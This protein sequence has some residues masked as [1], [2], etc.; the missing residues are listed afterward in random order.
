MSVDLKKGATVELVKT[1]SDDLRTKADGTKANSAGEAVR[2]QISD[3]KSHLNN[4][5][6]IKPNNTTFFD[7][8]N[9][10]DSDIAV[11]GSGLAINAS[12]QLF[13]ASANAKYLIIP[14]K[15]STTYILYVPEGNR[16]YVGENETDEFLSGNTITMLVTANADYPCTF[17]TGANAHY[18]Y[19]YI[20]SGDYDYAN[21]KEQI[22]LCVGTLNYGDPVLDNK[23]IGKLPAEKL[24]IFMGANLFDPVTAVYRTDRNINT[25]GTLFSSSLAK[26]ITFPVEPDTTYSLYVPD[27]NRSLVAEDNVDG[28]F[29]IG[30]THTMLVTNA[31][32]PYPIKFTTGASAKYVFVTI[33]VGDYDYNN[34]KAGIKLVK[35]KYWDR[36]E[37]YIPLNNM[38]DSLNNLYGANVLIFGDSITDCCN[39]TTNSDNE[40]TAYSWKNP[41]NSYIDGNGNAIAY[42]MWAK[43]LKENQPLGEIRNYALS[44]ASIISAEREAGSERLNLQYQ[45]D[46][47]LNDVDN[48]NGVFAVDHYVPDIVIFAIGTNDVTP[49]DTYE[50]AMSVVTYQTDGVSVDVSATMAQLDPTKFCESAR[51]AFLKIKQAFP[52]AQ[53]YFVLPLQ[54]ARYQ[55]NTTNMHAELKKIAERYGCI[56]IDGTFMSGV[57]AEFETVSHLGALL[58]DGLHPNDKGQNVMARMILSALKANYQP[59]GNGFNIIT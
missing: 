40:T 24:D 9:Y 32:L 31:T 29:A 22:R 25:S 58:K 6:P 10:F 43:I 44:G 30:S 56:I 8:V 52:L 17:T 36:P 2:E 54:R 16:Q 20:N 48:P 3:L 51:L 41:S 49:N 1:L 27:G 53:L 11:Y 13:T 21:K 39:I 5:F 59:F 35:G 50:Q 37:P 33:N 57:I 46:L 12:G 42:S 45:V 19:A 18:V 4:S 47:A 23:Y 28:T 34:K 7:D 38:D 14:V 26:T 55:Q 15:P